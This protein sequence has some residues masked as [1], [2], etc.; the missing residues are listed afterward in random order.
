MTNISTRVGSLVS[1]AIQSLKPIYTNLKRNP[2]SQ[3][4]FALA[5]GITSYLVFDITRA[6]R[7]SMQADRITQLGSEHDPF[8]K[9]QDKLLNGGAD[10]TDPAKA[11]K[12]LL[13]L[14]KL[15]IPGLKIGRAHV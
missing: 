15:W 14:P 9:L 11:D 6:R 7:F 5:A 2:R 1:H 3:A 10:Q 8:K 12:P 13:D 4:I